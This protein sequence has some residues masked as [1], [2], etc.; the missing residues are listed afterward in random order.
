MCVDPD[1]AVVQDRGCVSQNMVL[2]DILATER[3]SNKQDNFLR[4][5]PTV[6][7]C[8][9]GDGT[10]SADHQGLELPTVVLAPS[11]ARQLIKSRGLFHIPAQNTRDDLVTAKWPYSDPKKDQS[12]GPCVFWLLL[13]FFPHSSEW[14][15]DGSRYTALEKS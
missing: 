2:V 7:L 13:C 9:L 15:A 8:N 10:F 12:F 4:H 3:H 14:P 6:I 11:Q 1:Q 5:N